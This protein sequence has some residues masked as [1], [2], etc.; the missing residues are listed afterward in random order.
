MKKE[1][2]MEF[3]GEEGHF[4]T[5]FDFSA[6]CLSDGP[7]G[8]Y[9]NRE[10]PFEELRE[11]IFRSQQECMGVGF[12]SNI[13]ENH[14]EPRGSS[15]FLPAYAQNEQGIKMLG[16]VS[17]LL[18]GLP[19]LYQGQEIGMTNCRMNSVAE[20]DDINTKNEYRLA[21]EA[22]LTEQEALDVC[23]R[24]SRD[25]SRTPMQWSASENAGFTQGTP[26]LKVNPNYI[27]LN[28]AQQEQQGDSVLSYYKRL[29]ALRKSPEYKELFVYGAF[30]PVFQDEEMILAYRRVLDGKD[31]VVIANFDRVEKKIDKKWTIGCRLL[32]SNAPAAFAGDEM[33][34]APSQA[35]VL[36]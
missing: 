30:E 27:C 31:A 13:L 9:R 1:E 8:W 26:W 2:L 35:A 28:V 4:S 25:N 15:R 6:N 20:Y 24:Y 21:R 14:D 29:I 18:R 22:G 33:I 11:T 36:G 17:L 3:V 32:L 19:F 10:I 23:F 16:T 7:G 5:M 12:L 34:L